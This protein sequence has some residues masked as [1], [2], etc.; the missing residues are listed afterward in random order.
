[1]S[2]GRVILT[3]KIIMAL[4]IYYMAVLSLLKWVV[5]NKL[6][7]LIRI[8]L[9][10]LRRIITSEPPSPLNDTCPETSTLYNSSLPHHL[11]PRIEK[12]RKNHG[13]SHAQRQHVLLPAPSSLKKYGEEP[14]RHTSTPVESTAASPYSTASHRW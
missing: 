2:V 3:K 1:M 4:E 9:R 8:V 11:F 6:D 12:N 7:N 10:I 5:R 14:C 13:K